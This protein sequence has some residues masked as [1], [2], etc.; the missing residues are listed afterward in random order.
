MLKL[1]TA[2]KNWLIKVCHFKELESIHKARTSYLKH[3]VALALE[4]KGIV[5]RIS[6]LQYQLTDKGILIAKELYKKAT[7][8]K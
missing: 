6:F 4:S 7:I 1:T 2:Q 5:S 3:K 8:Q